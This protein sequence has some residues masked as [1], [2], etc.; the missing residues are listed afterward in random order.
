MPRF[1]VLFDLHDGRDPAE[2]ER[3]AAER[4]A[5]TVRKLPSVDSFEVYRIDGALGG[6]P[7]YRYVEVIEVNDM[8]QFDSDIAGTEMQE[9]AAEFQRW[10]DGPTFVFGERIV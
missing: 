3:W 7:P 2:Y 5:A 4:D 1:F 6:D 10:A 8:A 9:V